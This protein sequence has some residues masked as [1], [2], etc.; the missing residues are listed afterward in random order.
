MKHKLPSPSSM[1]RKSAAAPSP[2]MKRV[3]WN[4]AKA[5]AVAADT[6]AVAAAVVVAAET[7][8]IVAAETVVAAETAAAGTNHRQFSKKRPR[9]LGRFFLPNLKCRHPERSRTLVWRDQFR[10]S[11]CRLDGGPP[12]HGWRLPYLHIAWTRCERKG[13]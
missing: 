11:R 3:R 4:S 6:V 9:Q 12:S 7:V 1:A 8:A 10:G 2:S 5:A 13:K